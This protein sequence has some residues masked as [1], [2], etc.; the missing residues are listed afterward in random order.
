MSNFQE[1]Y[2]YIYIRAHLFYVESSGSISK[3]RFT[4]LN[5]CKMLSHKDPK[6][7]AQKG[8]YTYRAKMF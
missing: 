6:P 8:D 5:Q 4:R 1:I 2:K 7:L 3:W